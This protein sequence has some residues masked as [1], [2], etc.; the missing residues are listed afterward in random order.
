MNISEHQIEDALRAAP[1]PRPPAGLKERLVS[2][3]QLPLGRVQLAGGEGRG[4]RAEGGMVDW[5]KR[6]WPALLPAAGS[7]ACAVGIGVQQG[8]IRDLKESIQTAPQNLAVPNNSGVASVATNADVVPEAETTALEIARLREL[9]AKLSAEVSSLEHMQAENQQLRAQLAKPSSGTGLTPGEEETLA[10]AKER[11]ESIQCVNNMKQLGLAARIWANDNGDIYPTD[12]L[13]MTN[14]MSTPKILHCPGDH[15]RQM[16][17][18]FP[19]YTPANCSYEYMAPGGSETEPERVL[20]RCPIHGSIGLCDG[21]VQMG[22]AKTH[23]ENFVERDGKL[24]Y[25]IPDSRQPT[26]PV[27]RIINGVKQ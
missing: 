3:A 11:A 25:E 15:D 12:I 20:F 22:V 16:A 9:V 5:L 17:T 4:F 19:A 14:E 21:S 27:N 6:W 2:Q 7:L 26:P 13:A 23:P 8:E 24:F 1:T 10:K 18:N